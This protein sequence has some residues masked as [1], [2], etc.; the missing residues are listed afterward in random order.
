MNRA[1]VVALLAAC[2]SEPEQQPPPRPQ[3]QIAAEVRGPAA[4]VA[5]TRRVALRAGERWFDFVDGKP[6][7]NAA[8]AASIA[9]Q[10]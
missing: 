7:E 5:G 10:L 9:R 3:L 1:V 2:K 8:L 6:V 4:L